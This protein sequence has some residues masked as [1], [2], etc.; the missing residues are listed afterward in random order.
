[1]KQISEDFLLI[2]KDEASPSLR[3]NHEKLL[4]INPSYH[5]Q[6]IEFCRIF[7]TPSI[8]NATMPAAKVEQVLQTLH[9]TET[10][11]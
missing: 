10:E 3:A 11:V 8:Q 4:T 7:E 2:Y 9:T 6:W 1:M 5:A